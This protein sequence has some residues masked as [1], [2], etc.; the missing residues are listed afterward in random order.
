LLGWGDPEIFFR[1]KT[2]PQGSLVPERWEQR[3]FFQKSPCP[4]E[5]SLARTFSLR[6]L[7]FSKAVGR[8]LTFS[9]L[10]GRGKV[11]YVA[12]PPSPFPSLWLTAYAFLPFSTSQRL[13][14]RNRRIKN[15]VTKTRLSLLFFIYEI[16][17]V[18]PFFSA[19]ERGDCFL[20][21]FPCIFFGDL[22]W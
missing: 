12:W 22:C 4:A 18:F 1:E 2:C 20:L 15:N 19:H 14:D 8:A 11:A 21:P 10:P 3:S 9:S 17:Q 13:T 16:N 6:P 5:M 7:F